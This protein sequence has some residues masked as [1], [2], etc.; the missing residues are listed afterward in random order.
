M[1]LDEQKKKFVNAKI[2][3]SQSSMGLG[4]KKGRAKHTHIANEYYKSKER[5]EASV[6]INHTKQTRKDPGKNRIFHP[7]HTTTNQCVSVFRHAHTHKCKFTISKTKKMCNFSI[8]F[9]FKE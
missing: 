6:L 2:T 7:H 1:Q 4:L 9:D 3:V 8:Q 5:S